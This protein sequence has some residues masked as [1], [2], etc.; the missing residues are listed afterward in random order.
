LAIV[1]QPDAPQTRS[2]V[3]ASFAAAAVTHRA[4]TA[5]TA[6]TRIAIRS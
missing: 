2:P 4:K 6:T 5:A 1:V 3:G